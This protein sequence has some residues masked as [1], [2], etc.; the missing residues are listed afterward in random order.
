M[1][2]G[3][4]GIMPALI[5]IDMQETFRRPESEWF[6]SQY[7][8]AAENVMKLTERFGDSVIWTRFVRDPAEQGSW[9]A[10]YDRWAASRHDPDSPAWD[11][12]IPVPDGATVL[13]MHTFSKWGQELAQLTAGTEHLIICGV[14]TDCCVLATVLGAVDAGKMVTVVTDACAGSTAEAHDQALALMRLLAPMVTVTETSL[15]LNE[16]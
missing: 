6:V 10:Y 13:S 9:G 11:L 5:V 7:Q 8:P 15:L 12:T 16:S 2:T 4:K 1:T 3:M 14:A